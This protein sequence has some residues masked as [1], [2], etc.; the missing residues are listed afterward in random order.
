MRRRITLGLGLLAFSAMGAAWIL[1]LVPDPIAAG[2]WLREAGPVGALVFVLA[3]ATLQPWGLPG[4][5]FVVPAALVWSPWVAFALS[6]TGA[7]LASGVGFLFARWAG[8]EWARG[9]LGP[10]LEAYD[11]RLVAHGFGTVVALRMLFVSAPPTSWLLGVS[12]I[13]LGTF[14]V[15]SGVGFVPGIALI[16]LIG[17]RGL[18]AARDPSPSALIVLLGVLGA[19]LLYQRRVRAS[20]G[21]ALHEPLTDIEE[22]E[23]T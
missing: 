9:R 6:W 5:L 2:L 3:F 11:R 1:G 19:F 15:A 4:S 17:N 20:L 12:G 7:N 21:R 23:T 18:A 8:R 14:V 16:T 10:W 22:G 13:P